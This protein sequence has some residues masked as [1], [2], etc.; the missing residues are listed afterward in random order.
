MS[1]LSLD[2]LEE[3]AKNAQPYHAQPEG[4]THD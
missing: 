1:D 2:R 3:L 4:E